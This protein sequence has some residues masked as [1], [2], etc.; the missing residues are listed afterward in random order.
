MKTHK[1]IIC[2]ALTLSSCSALDT[3]LKNDTDNNEIARFVLSQDL[4]AIDKIAPFTLVRFMALD[5]QHITVMGVS[6]KSFLL[7]LPERC[8]D[9]RFAKKVNLY[10]AV[11]NVVQVKLDK[12]SRI[13]D[14]Y[15]PCTIT[16]IYLISQV[17]FDELARLNRDSRN[18][19][20]TLPRAL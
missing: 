4:K 2:V 6:K 3:T 11:D 15:S 18:G 7:T 16:G 14:D 8:K 10:T 12:I 13:G 20:N 17:Q 5:N 19:N 1:L 9:L